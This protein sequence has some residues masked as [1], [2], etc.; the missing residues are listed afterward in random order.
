MDMLQNIMELLFCVLTMALP[1]FLTIQIIL[2]YHLISE[3]CLTPAL[4]LG[5]PDSTLTRDHTL[6]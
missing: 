5:G 6:N 1:R 4:Y 2:Q 3:V